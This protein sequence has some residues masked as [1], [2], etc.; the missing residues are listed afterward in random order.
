M[1]LIY[2]VT[3]TWAVG[4]KRRLAEAE[5]NEETVQEIPSA[6]T[7][8]VRK[9]GGIKQRLARAEGTDSAS[10]SS[11]NKAN[12]D[13]LGPFVRDLRRMW[14]R[15][16]LSSVKLQ[17]LASS[18]QAQGIKGVEPLAAAGSYGGSPQNLFR[19][20]Q[21]VFGLPQGSCAFDWVEL[22]FKRGKK[23]AHPVFLPHIF[24]LPTT[25]NAPK[26]FFVILLLAET[27]VVIFGTV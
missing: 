16:E 14:C 20:F 19:A 12:W 15:G 25:K 11:T 9:G 23:T 17:S 6:S 4:I 24:S 10:T 7:G 27:R 8:P 5:Q 13:P 18:A 26:R 22:P 2:L 21:N 3:S 1:L